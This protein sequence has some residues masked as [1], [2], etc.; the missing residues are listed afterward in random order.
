MPVTS[1]SDEHRSMCWTRSLLPTCAPS[2]PSPSCSTASPISLLSSPVCS[3]LC[4]PVC[5][6][7]CSLTVPT[8]QTDQSADS[9]L[10]PARPTGRRV[11]GEGGESAFPVS[12]GDDSL[13]SGLMWRVCGCL[14]RRETFGVCDECV[15]AR[16]WNRGHFPCSILGAYISLIY[17]SLLFHVR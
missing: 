3:L 7:L 2:A 8:A 15:R 10:S 9:A 16:V 12:E 4:S 17:L 5:Y 13:L 1:A 14:N 6:P 11:C